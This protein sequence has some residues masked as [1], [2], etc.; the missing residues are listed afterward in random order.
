MRGT[1]A[2]REAATADGMYRHRREAAATAD[3]MEKL[4]LLPSAADRA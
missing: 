4:P 2:S 1:P 3:G